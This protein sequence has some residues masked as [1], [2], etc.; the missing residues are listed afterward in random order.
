MIGAGPS[1]LCTAKE[2]LQEG[3]S[4]TCF[5]R[6]AD[7]GGI[8]K[9]R[10]DPAAIGVWK[11][12]KLTS[13]ALV[14]SFSDF[15]PNA[16]A[17]QPFEHRHL[18][19]TEYVEYL[20]SYARHFGVFQHIRFES[21]VSSIA[22]SD[23]GGWIVTISERDGARY[24][25]Q[26]DAVAVCSGIHCVPA[27]P[28]LP[29]IETFQGQ[30]VHA[31][32]YKVP[33]SIHGR[34]AVFVGAGESGGEIIA[35]ASRRLQRSW[36]S[37]QRGAYVIPR[38]VNGLPNDYTSTRLLY[39]LPEFLVRRSDPKA[40][41]LVAR[42]KLVLFPFALVR[43]VIR[44]TAIATKICRGVFTA[45]RRRQSLEK[46]LGP[47]KG[48]A[49]AVS[50]LTVDRKVE[51]L[52]ASLRRR[53]GGNQF[54]TFATKT[55]AFVHAIAQGRCE[56]R[57][58]ITQVTP[59]GVVFADGTRAEA[60]ALVFC[61]G[62]EAA[63]APFIKVDIDLKRLYRGCLTTTY[64]EGL[65]FIGFLRPA[66]GAIPPMAEMQARWLAQ[67]LSGNIALPRADVMDA[68]I[69]QRRRKRSIYFQKIFERIPQIHDFSTFMDELAEEIGCKP[70]LIDH[71]LEPRLL[72]KLYTSAYCAV[73]FRLRGPHA[74]PSL[75]RRILLYAPSHFKSVHVLDIAFAKLASRAGF[76]Q[77][78]PRLSLAGRRP[79][80]SSDIVG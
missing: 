74:Q 75:A 65:A 73:Q 34:S 1:G 49:L 56:L 21:E 52:I 66:L 63:S 43:L 26:F 35:E 71:I 6:T 55:D 32:H 4:P 60:D 29:G 27:I 70:R 31:A 67:V 17:A 40:K 25:M 15:F 18:T 8:F 44:F 48:R 50:E 12:C 58:A 20:E 28:R 76:G 13:S 36:L 72:H 46:L 2:L 5:E 37:L 22:P 61:T 7:I 54:E 53:A 47:T 33:E 30:V 24:S 23:D 45:Q 80:T 78:R 11:S 39:S 59:S 42:L 38:L 19:H 77:F 64:R 9:Y 79:P 14:T 57:P 68:D 41:A 51:L 10:D 62:F 16:N 3:H 69:E